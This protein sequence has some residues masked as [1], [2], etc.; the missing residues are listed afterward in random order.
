[1]VVLVQAV[2]GVLMV[3]AVL[4]VGVGR[5][6][7]ARWQRHSAAPGSPAPTATAI[8]GSPTVAAA[9]PNIAAAS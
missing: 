1:M 5:M 3:V 8:P 6:V 2:A 9:A 7:A 4:A